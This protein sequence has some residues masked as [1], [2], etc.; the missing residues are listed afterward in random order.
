MRLTLVISSLSS[1]GA[2]RVMSIM[3]NYWAAKGWKITL[4][5]FDD[6][7]TPP[8]YNLDY[9][10]LHL[11]LGIA[12]DSPNAIISIWNNWQRIRT[13]RSA[14]CDSKPDTVISFMDKINVLTLLATRWLNI[15][16]LVSERIDP[17]RHCI[18]KIWEQLRQWTYPF[19][20]R[21]VVQ[22]QRIQSSFFPK[23]HART[24]IIPNPVVLP[25]VEK[26]LLDK[27][28]GERSLV[29]MGRLQQQ[30]GFDLLI[31]AF[32]KLKDRY[33]QWILTILG[34]GSL[35]S[36]LESLRS[37]L[38]LAEQIHFPGLVKNTSEFLKQADLFVMSSR[39]EGFPN[40]LCEAM[41][42]GLP[43]ISF[44]CPSGPREIIRDGVDGVLVP[45]EDV[46]ALA[47]AMERLMS[48]EQE[49]KRLAVNAP[50]VT[51]RFS[52]EN[53]MGMWSGLIE[54]VINEGKK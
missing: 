17:T 18:G 33:P 38:G 12:G 25:S 14:I 19:A 44:D 23:L 49:R 20:D 15:P 21:I 37:Q 53:V 8:F 24:C 10:V 7:T 39:F 29:A 1:G 5:T 51:Q 28:L 31:Q 41:A 3:A 27:V 6:N 16:V 45:T 50:C 48:D 43:V 54:E 22:T 32:A 40:A 34:E 52:L 26:E 30:K 4:M 11:P 13:L 2:E 9:R 35:R 36:Q 42:C 47:A 46:S